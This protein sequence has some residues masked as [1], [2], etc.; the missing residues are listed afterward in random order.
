MAVLTE[1]MIRPISSR[2]YEGCEC[3]KCHSPQCGA[4][5]N[6]G[7]LAA[8][9]IENVIVMLFDE[10]YLKDLCKSTRGNTQ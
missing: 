1:S 10:Q 5:C 3:G 4:S 8:F 9:K 2:N 7:H 6:I